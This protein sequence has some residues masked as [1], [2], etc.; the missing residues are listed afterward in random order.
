MGTDF[1]DR[2]ATRGAT[3]A[4]SGYPIAGKYDDAMR[5][6]SGKNRGTATLSGSHAAGATTLTLGSPAT[7]GSVRPGWPILLDRAGANP[8]IVYATRAG[9]T[10]IVGS[11]IL[12]DPGTPTVNTHGNATS[13]EWDQFNALG[14]GSAGL[15]ATGM[16]PAPGALWHPGDSLFYLQR[17]N[18]DLATAL[19]SASGATTTQTSADQINPNGHGV[20]IVLVTTVIGTG[21]ITLEIDGKDPVSGNYYS[22]LTGAAVTT[23]TTNVYTIFPGI[24]VAANVS[25]SMTLPRTWRVKCTA[26]NANAATYSV[27]GCVLA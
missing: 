10:P 11:T 15:L 14:A 23:N 7:A 27:G 4:D 19:I 20:Q 22:L 21:S 16:F 24:T 9:T 12:L 2:G 17:G 25:A 13:V 26:N 18:V 3:M 6:A 1:N 5:G 8:E